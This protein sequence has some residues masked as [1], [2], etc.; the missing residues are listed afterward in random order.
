MP[1]PPSEVL[2]VMF[3]LQI[4]KLSILEIPPSSP[5]PVPIPE[6]D[7]VELLTVRLPSKIVKMPI[8][9]R[10]FMSM[11]DPVPIPEPPEAPDAEIVQFEMRT[12]P[13]DE[14]P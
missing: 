14:V 11:A 12:S 8:V 2:A 10:P 13:T 7:P 6:P 4:V 3:P 5:F 9:E 1:E